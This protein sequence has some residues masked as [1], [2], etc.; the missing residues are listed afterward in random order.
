MWYPS[1]GF[2]GRTGIIIGGYIWSDDIGEA[3][4]KLTPAQ[5]IERA[6]AQGEKLHPRYRADVQRGVAVCW[7]KVPYSNGAWC[8]WS[9]ET[10][11]D[12]YRVLLKPDGPLFLAGEH[13]SNLRGW[14]EGSIL[15]AYKA[16]QAIAERAASR[17]A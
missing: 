6:I 11:R 1:T 5:R 9:E 2:H 14:Q 3:I 7:G 12:A 13:L 8:D 10:K 4:A 17:K 16:I 15:S